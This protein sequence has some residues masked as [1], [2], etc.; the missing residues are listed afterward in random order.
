MRIVAETS[1][2]WVRI[3]L[4]DSGTGISSEILS[5]VIR[6]FFTTKEK[7][8]GLGLAFTKRVIEADHHGKLILHSTLGQGT[9][10]IVHLPLEWKNETLPRKRT[11]EKIRPTGGPLRSGA[12]VQKT[13]R[14]LR[15]NV[16][17]INDDTVMLDK[18]TQLLIDEGHNV[19]GTESGVKAVECCQQNDYDVIVSDYHL[20]KDCSAT[21]TAIDF[22]PAI[23]KNSP[24]TP[25]ILTSASLDQLGFPDM[26]CDFF[27]E[28]NTSFWEKI[29][30]LVDQ[31][32]LLRSTMAQKARQAF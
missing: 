13:S 2:S 7:G 3:K 19:T 8:Y 26:Y 24:A 15:G 32:L 21:Q 28:I 27:L 6:P 30:G 11:P 14:K 25:I 22:V 17:V 16:L 12:A 10:V 29:V 4:S 5:Q 18:I 9:T 20:R 31:C 1:G 23:K